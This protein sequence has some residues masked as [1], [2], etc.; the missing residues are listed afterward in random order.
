MTNEL[1][2]KLLETE[3]A[4]E[5]S[6]KLSRAL[7]DKRDDLIRQ[8]ADAHIESLKAT[9]EEVREKVLRHF[10]ELLTGTRVD[11]VD[12]EQAHRARLP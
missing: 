1:L 8:L 12:T 11:H 3:D 7:S 5:A 2:S 9:P 6:E 10:R 4:L